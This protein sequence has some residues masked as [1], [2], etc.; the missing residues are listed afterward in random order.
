MLSR[1]HPGTSRTRYAGLAL[2]ALTF[3]AACQSEPPPKVAVPGTPLPTVVPPVLPPDDA[4]ELSRIQAE[5][6]A[7]KDLTA[8]QL[9]ERYR[10]PHSLVVRQPGTNTNLDIIQGSPMALTPAELTTLGSSGLVISGNKA[11]PS[12]LYGYQTLYMADLPLYVSADSVMHAVHASYEAILKTVEV[13]SLSPK[14]LE[15]L[16][17]MRARLGAGAVTPLGAQAE[18]DVDFYLAVALSLLTDRVAAPVKGADPALVQSFFDKAKA[19]S[20]A[21]NEVIFGVDRDMDF[22]QFKPRSHY[23]DSDELKRYFRAM[24]WL[25]RIDLRI[26]E[27][28]PDL[29]QLFHRRQ[30]E[31]AYA[32][33]AVMD[34]TAVGQWRQIDETIE[35]FVGESDNM[36]LPELDAL[37]TD[38]GLTTAKDLAQVDDNTIATKILTRG[39]GTQRI[40]SHIMINGVGEGTMPLSSIFL[41]LGQRYVVDSHVFSNVVYDRVQRGSVKRM[42]PDP[43]DAAFAA[44]GNDQA[45][46]LLTD[47]LRQ[48][49][50][51]PDLHAMR[52]LVDAH[53]TSFWSGNL[54]NR[55]LSALR[56]LSPTD[57]LADPEAHGL[58]PSVASEAWGRRILNTQLASWAEL[59]HDTILYAKQSY[60]GGAACEFPDAY[61]DPYPRFWQALV[62]YA[63]HARQVVLGLGLEQRIATQMTRYFDDVERVT[64]VLLGMAQA[65]RA[66]TPF[67]AEQMAFINQAVRI[68]EGCGSPAGAEGWF[69]DLYFDR[70]QGADFNPTI[71][72]VHTQPTDEVGNPVGKVLHVGT[73]GPRLMVVSLETCSGVKAY[74]GLAS[75]Y[76][77]RVTQDFQRLDDETWSSEITTTTPADVRWMS[78]IVVR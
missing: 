36:R 57:E 48:Y 40:S 78:D 12:F 1:E 41:L 6:Q 5:L 14:L 45:A 44:L 26:I 63:Q 53:P 65:Q 71:A 27:T 31:G 52:F 68:Q 59:R 56:A 61:V 3:T 73:G 50:Y 38:L 75:S 17:S 8:D 74:A 9:I 67:T 76:F 30:L 2:T 37:L 4:A 25:G 72:D 55:W 70:A 32:I 15:L 69:A 18:E 77:E 35:A 13:A 34:P 49:S 47:Q 16:T 21:A 22:S 20:G 33:R 60:T 39:Y 46:A 43:L 28:Q 29:T 54:Y 19:A 51:A 24:M 58:P 10:V 66:G 23:N 62:E 11:F 7:T 42:M 64:T